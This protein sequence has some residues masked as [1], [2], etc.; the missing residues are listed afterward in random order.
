MDEAA[1][2]L[3]G[4]WRLFA[5]RAQGG[6]PQGGETVCHP[7]G[8]DARGHLHYGPDGLMSAFLVRAAFSDATPDTPALGNFTAYFA[9]WWIEGDRV[10]HEVLESS[11]P[12]RLKDRLVRVMSWQ[13][14]DLVLTTPDQHTAKG[15]MRNILH[16][17]R[18]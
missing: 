15:T 14:E 1:R 11:Q 6:G 2:R 12:W 8:P 13:G 9:R 18:M 16:W 4:G 3:V 7:M 5:W 10:I 17:R